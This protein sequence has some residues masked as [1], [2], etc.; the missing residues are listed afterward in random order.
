MDLVRVSAI[1]I[2]QRSLYVGVKGWEFGASSEGRI[3]FAA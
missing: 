3:R 1:D 2:V